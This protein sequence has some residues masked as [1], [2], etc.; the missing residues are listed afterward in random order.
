MSDSENEYEV[1][2][3]GEQNALIGILR[4]F[5][6]ATQHN[7]DRC[8]SFNTYYLD[9]KGAFRR[10]GYSFRHRMHSIEIDVTP[11]SELKAISGSLGQVSK[12]LE[13]RQQGLDPTENYNR[14]ACQANYPNDAPMLKDP[15][16]AI[17][18]AT[19]QT[20]VESRRMVEIGHRYV[21]VEAALDS[22][23]YMRNEGR[24]GDHWLDTQ[25]M[26]ARA[27][28]ELEFELK[29]S[30][31]DETAEMFFDWVCKHIVYTTPIE[32]TQISKSE[33]GYRYCYG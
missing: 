6:A 21:L 30:Q 3:L 31:D 11:A 24:S 7:R 29:T 14:M 33:R 4:R 12:R 25:L 17:D 32:I 22:I 23:T 9:C 20:R 15:T 16:F 13:I 26:P 10:A 28:H 2:L 27:E 5:N 1:K 8:Y 19:A 18:F